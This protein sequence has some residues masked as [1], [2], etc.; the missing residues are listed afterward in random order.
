MTA[1]YF[2]QINADNVVTDVHVVH[3][4]YMAANPD[5]YTG[6]WVETFFDTAGKTYA[7]IGYTYD[8]ATQDFSAPIY[9]PEP[10]PSP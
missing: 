8:P 9:I 3:A 2:A 7:G 1:Q 5:R 6:I 4:D 10:V